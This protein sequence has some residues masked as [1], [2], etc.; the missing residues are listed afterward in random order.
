MK[1]GTTVPSLMWVPEILHS[2]FISNL[3]YHSA[4]NI[5]FVLVWSLCKPFILLWNK[6]SRIWK[7]LA[8]TLNTI[9]F[10]KN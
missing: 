5:E 10:F 9:P 4:L 8:L 2:K 1:Q 6:I 3:Y 7:D